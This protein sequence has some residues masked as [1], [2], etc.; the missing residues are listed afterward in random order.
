MSTEKEAPASAAPKSKRKPLLIAATSVFV[1]AGA[2]YGAYWA[3]V[4]RYQVGTDDAYVAGD[5]VQI[6]P[7]T[8]G[9]VLAINAD[10]TDFVHAGDALVKLNEADARVALDQAEAQ[11]AQTVRQVRTLFATSDAL[12]ATVAQRQ[13][14]VTKARE[15]LKR[16]QALAGTGAIAGEELEHARRAVAAA[17][18]ALNAAREQLASNSA[19]IDNTTVAAH[20]NVKR[21]AAQVRAAYLDLERTT[22]PAPV[23]G[24]VAKRSVQLGQRVS[25]GAPL[26]AV[27]PLTQVWVD[28]NF[29]EGQLEHMRIGQPVTLIADLYGSGVEY[30]GTVDGLAAG[31]GAAF[32]LI[33]AQNASGNWIKVVQRVPVRVR[34]DPEELKAHPLRIGLSMQVEV[35]V[36]DQSGHQLTSDTGHR[37]VSSTAV[38]A[39]ESH[40]ADALV[41]GIVTANLHGAPMLAS[42]SHP[43]LEPLID[44]HHKLVR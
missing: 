14:D 34:L 10:D 13:S 42:D 31:T 35:N 4:S 12:A 43:T 21:A 20:P 15:D 24:V 25:P 37:D 30:H 38:F 23:D 8:A 19:L 17:E 29:K 6:T 2:A 18:A 1:L 26:M 27:V 32:A 3:L 9:T 41:D 39:R 11:L 5:V 33:P 16:R 44:A 36:R 28:A 22:I 7:Q 40:G